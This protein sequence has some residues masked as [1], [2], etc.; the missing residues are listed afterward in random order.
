[1]RSIKPVPGQ[2]KVIQL[3]ML[4]DRTSPLPPQKKKKREKN[5][6]MLLTPAKIIENSLPPPPKTRP[7]TGCFLHLPYGY[8]GS[9]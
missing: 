4:K 3:R 6:K 7:P 2:A 1:M 9:C 8:V 5:L